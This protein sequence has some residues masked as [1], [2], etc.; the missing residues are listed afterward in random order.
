[1]SWKDAIGQPTHPMRKSR[2][3]RM[4]AG[5]RRITSAARKWDLIVMSASCVGT[6]AAGAASHVAPA[7][8]RELLSAAPGSPGPVVVRR[9]RGAAF[10]AAQ[11]D[12]AITHIHCGHRKFERENHA[13]PQNRNDGRGACSP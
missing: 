9:S 4:V 3:T 8:L 10:V 12:G 5:Q 6:V 11:R 1:M 13:D 2:N 7:Q